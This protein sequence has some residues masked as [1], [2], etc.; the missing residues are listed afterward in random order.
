VQSGD[1][2]VG[3]QG[4]AQRVLAAAGTDHQDPHR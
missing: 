4:P 3:G 1:L 2:R